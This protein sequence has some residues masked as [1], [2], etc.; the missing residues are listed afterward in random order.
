MHSQND[1]SLHVKYLQVAVCVD[2]GS[3][4][5]A[6]VNGPIKANNNES[7]LYIWSDAPLI[8]ILI[9]EITQ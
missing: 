2:L 8:V 7:Q 5:I 9:M 6:N 3:S 1:Q 4:L